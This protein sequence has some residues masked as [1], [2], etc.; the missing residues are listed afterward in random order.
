[1]HPLF[2]DT[3]P[4]DSTTLIK[5]EKVSAKTIAIIGGLDSNLVMIMSRIPDREESVLANHH[6]EALGGKG[7]NSA[8]A[9]YRTCHKSLS[10]K[11]YTVDIVSGTAIIGPPDARL[12][13][14]NKR[15]ATVTSSEDEIIHVKMIGVVGDDRYDEKFI[16]ELNKNGVDASGIVTVPDTRSSICFVMVEDLTRE[17]R[18]LFMLGAT[19]TWTEKDFLTAESLGGKVKPDLVVA[20]MEIHK[21]EV[22][23]MLIS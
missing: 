9:T 20:Q 13:T 21:D 15:Q 10:A 12:E 19:T 22:E 14:D 18:Y 4:P 8:I 11:Q 17:N 1:V 7:P 6:Q 23:T 2:A 16:V 5:T 3:Q